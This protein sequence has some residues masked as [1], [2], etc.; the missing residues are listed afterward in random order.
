MRTPERWNTRFAAIEQSH[1]TRKNMTRKDKQRAKPAKTKQKPEARPTTETG[2]APQELELNLSDTEAR[3]LLGSTSDREHA[4]AMIRQ[5]RWPLDG[6]DF[7]SESI[8]DRGRNQSFEPR[9]QCVETRRCHGGKTGL[10]DR[11]IHTIGE[12]GNL[13]D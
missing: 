5:N 12:P 8:G 11:G 4:S 3:A 2:L 13:D 10:A 7:E 1:E 9:R 6:V